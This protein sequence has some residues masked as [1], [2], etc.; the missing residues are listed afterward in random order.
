MT[1]KKKPQKRTAGKIRVS[2]SDRAKRKDFTMLPEDI[3]RLVALQKR[4]QISDRVHN[5]SEIVRAGLIALE[6]LS[7]EK[8][9]AILKEV[10]NL[11]KRQL[12]QLPESGRPSKNQSDK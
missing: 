10:L 7:S 4:S 8:F 3:E 6:K 12:P 2:P 11:K 9:E 1:Q 5:Q